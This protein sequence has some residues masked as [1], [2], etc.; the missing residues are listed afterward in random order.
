MSKEKSRKLSVKRLVPLLVAAGM[1]FAIFPMLTEQVYGT[2]HYTLKWEYD[3]V[4]ISIDDDITPYGRFEVEYDGGGPFFRYGD[5]NYYVNQGSVKRGELTHDIETNENGY[6]KG[7]EFDRDDLRYF[8][9]EIIGWS[10]ESGGDIVL[11]NYQ[12]FYSAFL[13]SGG[14][15]LYPVWKR[16]PNITYHNTY[17]GE[18]IESKGA[19]RVETVP[20][21]PGTPHPGMYDSPEY[22]EEVNNGAAFIAPYRIFSGWAKSEEGAENGDIIYRGGDEITHSDHMDLYT[23]WEQSRISDIPPA[24]V[25]NRNNAEHFWFGGKLWRKLGASDDKV[26]LI[27]DEDMSLG[28]ISPE[29]PDFGSIYSHIKT[30]CITGW[31]EGF[32]SAEQAAV[33]STD[34]ND[35]K[36]PRLNQAKLFL[37]SWD[38]AKTYFSGNKDR[39]GQGKFTKWWFLRDVLDLGA[40]SDSGLIFSFVVDDG[41]YYEL[42]EI[43]N[44]QYY[45]ENYGKNWTAGERPAFVLD[46][47][48]VLFTS[49]AEKENKF[50]DITD[51]SSFGMYNDPY[52]N[53]HG[54]K[55]LTLL[56]E[57]YKDFAASVNHSNRAHVAPG[58]TIEVSYVNAVTDTETEKNRYISAMLCDSN[59]NVIGY[60]SMKPSASSGT[61]ELKLPRNLDLS[62]KDYTLKVYNEQQSGVGCTDYASSFSVITLTNSEENIPD[63][64]TSISKATVTGIKAKTWTGKALNQSPVVKL[65]GKTLKSGTDY[66]VAYKN[67]KNVGKATLTIRGKGSYTGTITKTF[68][69]NPQGTSIAKLT[70]A[71][72]AFTV[73]WKKQ[74]KKMSKSRITGYQIQLATNKKFIKGKKTVTVK[75]Y[76]TVSKKV[77]KLKARKTYYVRVRT[78]Q[79]VSGAKY[80]SPWSKAKTV[81]TN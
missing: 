8:N 52:E 7:D 50:L 39:Q 41:S 16:T 31:Y 25:F 59:G 10:T 58:G 71:G 75:G 54:E 70:K 80:Y 67:N 46:L 17:T 4:D 12:G 69:I 13:L 49:T 42:P 6:L 62:R 19:R 14:A 37:L 57:T 72:K 55:K 23:V 27:Y 20:E 26:L 24:E 56:D 11:R 53:W 30:W 78:Y 9:Y 5:E 15:T 64:K 33:R 38:E 44:G 81:K 28:F 36:T 29:F 79:I 48:R 74:A 61:W 76:Q 47:S 1:A 77:T 21:N 65:S 35:G 3:Y 2:D 43:I 66:T 45:Y 22:K 51:G 32:S 60:A 34:K 18:V 68:K 73:Q 63:S 40:N